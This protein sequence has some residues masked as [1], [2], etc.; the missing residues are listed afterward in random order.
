MVSILLA[1]NFIVS[2]VLSIPFKKKI[3]RHG[4]FFGF[5]GMIIYILIVNP[6]LA[7]YEKSKPLAVL[8]NL[9]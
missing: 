6:L 1:L 2:G 3:H 8:L 7:H 5:V 9:D 4:G